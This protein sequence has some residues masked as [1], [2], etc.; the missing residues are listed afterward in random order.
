[1]TTKNSKQTKKPNTYNLKET[2]NFKYPPY[3]LSSASASFW[4]ELELYKCC[5][6][7]LEAIVWYSVAG[8]VQPTHVGV[9]HMLA[10]CRVS[11]SLCA[12]NPSITGEEMGR[13]TE[14]LGAASDEF[15][16]NTKVFCSLTSPGLYRQ[17]CYG[18]ISSPPK[19]LGLKDKL[20]RCCDVG[21]S[22]KPTRKRQGHCWVKA[23]PCWWWRTTTLVRHWTLSWEQDHRPCWLL[24]SEAQQKDAEQKSA[25]L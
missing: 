1:M 10:Q 4:Q 14:G 17:C 12:G 21:G 8:R 2:W 13:H 9:T 15:Q 7:C 5:R 11:C 6:C 22:V 20:S 16:A 18:L 25:P 23:S 3:S 24:S 19:I